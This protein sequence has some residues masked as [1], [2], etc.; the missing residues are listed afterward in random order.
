LAESSSLWQDPDHR[1]AL[2]ADARA[3]LAFHSASLSADGG[4][5]PLGTDGTP[6]HGPAQELHVTTRMVHSYAM[7]QAWGAPDCAA[8]IDAGM[9]ALWHW[10]RDADQGGYVW[11]VHGPQP[12]DSRKLAYGHVFVLLA[13]S[14]AQ[15]VGHEDAPRLFGDIAAVLE[16]H[17][18]DDAAGRLREEFARDWQ[19]ISRYR[20][21]NANMHGVE[22]FLAAYEATG[23]DIWLDRAGRILDF[24]TGQMAGAHG[25][26]IP[27]HY[28]ESWQV[29]PDFR[30]DPVFRPP[31]TTP[32]HS[33]EFARLL[34][35]HWDLTGRTDPTALP[36]AR[37]LT[38]TALSDAWL[39]EGGLAYTLTP[40]RMVDQAVRL[41]WPVAEGLGALA[42]LQKLDPTPQD[43]AWYARLHDFARAHFIDTRHGGWHPELGADGLPAANIFSGK[44]DIYHALQADLLA[45]VPGVSRVFAGLRALAA[46]GLD[47]Q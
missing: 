1:A 32:G 23:Q 5:M 34:L 38:Q 10:H 45:L 7:G 31:G 21:M 8:I 29:D 18:W 14:S 6:Q 15:E 44:P 16:R 2:S 13:A 40:G 47:G 19:P 37:A 9:R 43:A 11:A 25:Q 4:F 3:L 35:Q 26:R 12:Q 36:R 33:L 30:G 41:W 46:R 39:P 28:T 42:M 22:A 27:E 24:F 20:G 17:F